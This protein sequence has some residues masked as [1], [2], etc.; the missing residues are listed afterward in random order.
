MCY[1]SL[2]Q[3]PCTFFPAVAQAIKV[4]LTLSPTTCTIERSFSTLRRVKKWLRSTI[5]NE[6][7]N[8]LCL[9]SVHREKVSRQKHQLIEDIKTNFGKGKRHIKFLFSN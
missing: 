7:L 9:I 5:S 8:G 2:F 4:L 6:R 1:S 3:N